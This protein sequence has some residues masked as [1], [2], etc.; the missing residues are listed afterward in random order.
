MASLHLCLCVIPLTPPRCD[1]FSRFCGGCG[2]PYWTLIACG[3][4][5]RN[6]TVTNAAVL[7]PE[8]P[9]P[10][11]PDAAHFP[12]MIWATNYTRM[13]VQTL[14]TLFWAGRGYAPKC[15]IDGQNIQDWLQGHFFAAYRKLGEHIRD[16]GD[17]LDVCVIGWDNINEPNHGYLGIEHLDVQPSNNVLRVGPT[18][19]AFQGMRL[20]MGEALSVETW[21]FGSFGAKKDGLVT[22]DPQGRKA[23]LD[24][25]AEAQGSKW[26]WE[27]D[28]SWRLGEC[29]WAQH[30]VW[31]IATKTLLRPDYFLCRPGDESGEKVDFGE[32]FWQPSWV[33]WAAMI[34]EVH[35]EAIHFIHPP[36]YEIPPPFHSDVLRDSVR[37]R[38]CLSIH[39]YDGLTLVTKHW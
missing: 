2:A 14:N 18:P 38:A 13:A 37:D 27:R 12:A 31:D 7:Q 3:L 8:W 17:L 6:F 39:F 1:Q 25:D 5:P 20:A 24:A 33:K 10:S 35:P 23:W 22:I 4:N 21:H 15:I 30:G 9:D 32:Q 16:A 29:I 28:P 34:R 19:T 36:V 26:G 11:Q